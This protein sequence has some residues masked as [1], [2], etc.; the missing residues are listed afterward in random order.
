MNEKQKNV[1]IIL[2]VYNRAEHTKMVLKYLDKNIGIADTALYIFSDGAKT[3]EEQNVANVRAML[4][5]FLK[6]NHF[7][8]VEIKESPMNKGLAKSVISG[9]SSVLQEYDS[10]IVLEDDLLASVD[11]YQYMV[12]ALGYYEED[13]R[14][15]SIAGYSPRMKQ[16]EK[17]SHEV[18]ASPRA[19][20]WG[21]AT[22]K[23][24]WQTIDWEV[25]DYEKFKNNQ[26]LRKAFDKRSP[27][28]AHMLDL[29]MAGS[30]DSWAI[31]W[32][33]QQ[34]KSGTYT[35]N[36]VRSKIKNIGNDGTGTHNET[37][38]KWDIILDNEFKKTKFEPMVIDKKVF[39]EY[40]RYFKN[41][42]WRR[43]YKRLLRILRKRI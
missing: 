4:Q 10:V 25:S 14:V 28:M 15:W 19:G 30:I 33:Y 17:T 29:Q 37:D 11:F 13:R 27:G 32:C 22:W 39:E 6:N 16:L 43:I 2:F 3:G 18:Y 26:E 9:V 40:N 38:D 41:P 35:I 31:R 36:P 5:E 21:W 24:R 1:P 12:D 42:L 34:H 8:M 20:S 23:D 7:G